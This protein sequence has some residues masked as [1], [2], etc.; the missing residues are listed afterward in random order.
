M[1]KPLAFTPF[2][3]ETPLAPDESPVYPYDP[4]PEQFPWFERT[5][6]HDGSWVNT[7][8]EVSDVDLTQAQKR[9]E[10]QRRAASLDRG[11]GFGATSVPAT[12][13]KEW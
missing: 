11:F 1:S 4:M 5:N 3:P 6:G 10:L 12:S 9:A 13:Y 8:R 2:G 7:C